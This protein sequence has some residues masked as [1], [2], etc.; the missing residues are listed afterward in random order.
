M[1]RLDAL[2]VLT[3]R[4]FRGRQRGERRS[5]KKGISVEFADYRNY[6]R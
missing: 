1:A 2:E 4:V 3:H 6:V 5:R